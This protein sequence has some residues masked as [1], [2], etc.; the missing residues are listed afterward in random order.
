MI[1]KIAII[2]KLPSG[3]YRLYSRKKDNSGHRRNLGTYDSLSAVKNREKEISFFKSHSDDGMAD[4]SET[5]T[6]GRLSNIAA[7]LEEA[8]F[9]DS[10]DKVYMAMDHI[11]K[12]LKEDYI[13]DP[14]ANSTNEQMNTGGGT[15][16]SDMRPGQGGSSWSAD[17]GMVIGK[18]VGIANHL[19]KIGMYDEAGEIDELISNAIE[20]TE[21]T[22]EQRSIKEYIKRGK[23][24]VKD[25]LAEMAILEEKVYELD[26]KGNKKEADKLQAQWD[27]LNYE[28]D[29]LIDSLFNMDLNVWRN[30]EDKADDKDM[31]RA[32]S[33]LDKLQKTKET[34]DS[35]KQEEDEKQG[36]E[37]VARS[38]GKEGQAVTDNQNCGMFSG[39]SDS[40]MYRG[41]GSLE[42]A[43][44]PADR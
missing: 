20:D 38:N 43:Y 42:G 35:H 4:D 24:R 25:L 9:I 41:Y 23:Q 6:L 27:D 1:I 19:D 2:K 33:K 30:N 34:E 36:N 5:K 26:H 39:F 11:D 3:K 13:I 17:A 7:F 32:I 40:Y 16:F 22:I 21:L 10:A 8:G 14:F 31:A 44:G 18:L 37:A 12:D 29:R 15:G 28:R